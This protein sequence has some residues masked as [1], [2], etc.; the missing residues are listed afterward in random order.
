MNPISSSEDDKK[1]QY[2]RLGQIQYS[3]MNMPVFITKTTRVGRFG[4]GPLLFVE[5]LFV[6]EWARG[7]GVGSLLIL[8]AIDRVL[9]KLYG[10]HQLSDSHSQAWLRVEVSALSWNEPAIRTY[11]RLGFVNI[12]KQRGVQFFAIEKR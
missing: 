10:E 2:T 5:D 11:E 6:E 3:V 9:E 1:N 8:H 12:T 4:G 7:R